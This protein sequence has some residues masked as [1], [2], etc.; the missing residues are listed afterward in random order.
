[1]LA[2]LLLILNVTLVILNSA[3]CSIAICVVAVFKLVLPTATLKAKG[4][5]LA[6]KIMWLWA[7]INA[8]ILNISNQIEWDI[9]GGEELRKEGWYLMISNHLSWTDIVVL[10]CVFKDR[11]PMPKFFLKQ[12][13]LYVPFI[14]MACWALDMPFMRRYSREYLIRHPEK[15]GQDLATTRRSCAKFKHTPTTVVNY[16]EGTRFTVQKQRKSKAGYDYLLQPKTGGIAYTL[17]AMGDQFDNII[18]VTL[19]Y[20]DN[21]EK[22]FKDALMGRMKRIVVRTKVLPVDE[23]VRGDY[24]NDKPYKRQFQQWLGEIWKDKDEVL[25][26][27]HQDKS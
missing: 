8:A 20:P 2:H 12:Q 10:C 3:L 22:P 16:V 23:Q 24:F 1:M 25:K 9:E 6:N 13:L 11:I 14:G 21:T 26:E 5:Q 7:T 19:A 4:T 18:D 27:L 15:R 17:A